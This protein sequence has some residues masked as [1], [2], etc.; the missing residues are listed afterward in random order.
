MPVLPRP[1]ECGVVMYRYRHAIEVGCGPTLCMV[2]LAPL[3]DTNSQTTRRYER[4]ARLWGYG[5]VIAVNVH[6]I[7]V[8]ARCT[9]LNDWVSHQDIG[10][11]SANA[12][13]VLACAGA[14]ETVV[15]A[16]GAGARTA[17]PA[18]EA[19]IA[20]GVQLMCLGINADG[21]PKHPSGRG[22]PAEPMLRL[23]SSVHEH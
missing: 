12:D 22:L 10:M 18:R 14:A 17:S 11:A 9:G 3:A 21:S 16:W 19:L 5:K 8:D 6:P 2:A 13:M 4:W 23:W 20:S 15:A 7:I 1:W